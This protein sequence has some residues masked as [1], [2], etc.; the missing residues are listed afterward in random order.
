M[1]KFKK[2]KLTIKNKKYSHRN[3]S[4]NSNKGR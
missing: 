3:N 1:P 2:C 4:N